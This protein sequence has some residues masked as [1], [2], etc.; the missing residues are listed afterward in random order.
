[1]LRNR[2]KIIYYRV[3]VLQKNYN[4]TKQKRFIIMIILSCAKNSKN[5]LS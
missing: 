4:L 2:D 1:M 3:K 5:I